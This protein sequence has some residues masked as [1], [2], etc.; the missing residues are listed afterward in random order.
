VIDYKATIRL[1]ATE[2]PMKANLAQ[3]EPQLLARWAEEGV[4]E[5][6]LAARAGA[7]AF[8]FHDGPPYANGAI[9]YGHILNKTLKD[10][11]IKYQLLVGRYVRFV[12]GW[13]CHG[14]PIEL[15]VE[16]KL[17]L[18]S[19]SKS[20]VRAA[21]R[22]E[23]EMWIDTQRAQFQR[24]GVFGTWDRPYLTMHPGYEQGIVEALAAFVRH[25]LVY[26]GKKPV[27]WCGHDRTALA[28]AEVEYQPHTSP[29][30]YVKFPVRGAQ[31]E[32]LARLCGLAAD[33]RV[34][35]ASEPAGAAVGGGGVHAVVWTTTP[36]TL[37]AN[38]AIA[39][40][41]EHAYALVELDPRAPGEGTER[42]LLAAALVERVLAATG[43][44]G[45]VVGS[46][47]T[48]GALESAGLRARHPFEERDSPLLAGD[49]VTLEAGTGL[50][51]TAPGH[52]AEDYALGLRHGLPPFAPLDD[53][54]RFTDEV[55]PEWRG[56]HVHEAN[57]SIVRLLAE[58][59]LLA[60]REGETISHNYPACWRCKNPVVFRATTQWFIAL[61]TPMEGRAD[62]KTLR[63][64]ALAEIDAVAA[65]RDLNE[66]E[67]SGWI[68]AWG[69]DRIH[70]MIAQRPDWCISRQRAWGV[71]IPAV[72][73]E[74][75]GHVALDE[76]LLEHVGALFAR[77]GADV[78]YGR[79]AAELLPEGYACAR[80]GSRALALDQNILDVWFESGASFWAVMRE[81]R[82]G[83]Q[84]GAG[85]STLPVD[86][87]LEGSDQHRG[88]FHASLLVGCALLGRAPYKRVLTHGFV[89]DEQGRPYS[90]SEIRRRQEAGEQVEYLDPQD[91]IARE[92]AEILRLWAAYE[93]YRSDVRYS[94]AHLAQVGDAYRKVRNTI[95]FLLGNLGTEAPLD[96]P[97][98]ALDP[99]DEWARARLRR[100]VA[101]VRAAYESFDFRGVYHRTVELCTGEWSA[102]YLDVLKDRLYC[103]ATDSP[104]RQSALATLDRIARATLAALAPILCFTADEAWRHLPGEA[105][106]SVFLSAKLPDEPVRPGDAALLARAAALF[107]V[108]DAVHAALEP[109]VKA[110]RIAH[111]REASVRLVLPAAERAGLG[112]FADHLP[113]LLGVSEVEVVEGE[114]LAA[115]VGKTPHSP[116]ARC[117]R[118]LPDVGRR[119]DYPDLCGRCAAVMA[120]FPASPW[121]ATGGQT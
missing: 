31:A 94:R 61:D 35:G 102:F 99:L 29:S 108:R 51:H 115:V 47:V 97:D 7:P 84:A 55:R 44:T 116:C 6:A 72:H 83:H 70:G 54:A 5:R 66:G 42:W 67:G 104:R 14:L 24:L 80:C 28:E 11:V 27:Y 96:V 26:R 4:Y 111:R 13:D 95:R 8:V 60:N 15:N 79:P 45:R 33:G 32:A 38:L 120:T 20:E 43:R 34:G 37:P 57:P 89:C 114:S 78:W 107:A 105:G 86:L 74:S 49:H 41:P 39:V 59:G 17:K 63:E 119:P 12:P 117:W 113:E 2:F 92:G 48:G 10:I 76:P 91:V 22:R 69:R 46:P 110:R 81:G 88:W 30:I 103:D 77:E 75:C 16:R 65:G 56:K 19:A 68:P 21:C 25:G 9:H 3:R 23:A 50:V 52:G 100:Y 85:V 18:R 53:A 93:D 109:Q 64:L 106:R 58:R 82:Y 40:H 71:P 1:P 87:Y 62:R 121:L 90:K 73:C 98:D 118:H 112:A 36:W 101:D